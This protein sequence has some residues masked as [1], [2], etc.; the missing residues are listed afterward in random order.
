MV[1]TKQKHLLLYDAPQKVE[2][3]VK[4]FELDKISFRKKNDSKRPCMFELI[5]NRKGKIM[6]FKGTYLFDGLNE[7]KIDEI[8]PTILS[9]Y[10]N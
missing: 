1:F 6:D 9:A 8:H 10:N 7:Q 4:I 5:V 3:F 2:N